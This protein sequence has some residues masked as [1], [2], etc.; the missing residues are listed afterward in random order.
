MDYTVAVYANWEVDIWKKLR[1]AKKAAI[2]RYTGN[3]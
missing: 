2:T 1:N 3:R